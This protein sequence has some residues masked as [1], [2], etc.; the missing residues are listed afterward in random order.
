VRVTGTGLALVVLF[1]ASAALSGCSAEAPDQEEVAAWHPT[2]DGPIPAFSGPYESEFIEAYKSTI[3][4]DAHRILAKGTITDEDYAAAGK[5]YVK[6]MADKGFHVTI[7]GPAGQMTIDGTATDAD[8]QRAVAAK[9]SCGLAFDDISIL[10][11]ELL[12]NPQNLDENVIVSACLVREGIAPSTYGP[13]DYARD[14][15][16][17]KFPF[18]VDGADFGGCIDNPLGSP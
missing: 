13:E 5:S 4:P 10:H 14:S 3:D 1:A 9:R 8:T 12:R 18:N 2:Y 17:Q 11:G 15:D 7:D 6:C 16:L